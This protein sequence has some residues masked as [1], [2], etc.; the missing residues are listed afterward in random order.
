MAGP[1]QKRLAPDNEKVMK[2]RIT[3]TTLDNQPENLAV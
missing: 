2:A 1:R 3:E